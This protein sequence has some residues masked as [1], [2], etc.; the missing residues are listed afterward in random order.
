MFYRAFTAA[1]IL[2]HYILYDRAIKLTGS[3]ENMLKAVLPF[4]R[5]KENFIY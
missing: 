3:A 4:R 1:K 5:V 2:K